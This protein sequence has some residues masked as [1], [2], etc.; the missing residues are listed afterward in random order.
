MLGRSLRLGALSVTGVAMLLASQVGVG[1]TA[2][3]EINSQGGYQA[4]PAKLSDGGHQA[5]YSWDASWKCRIP[6]SA[7]IAGVSTSGKGTVQASYG[8]WTT[9]TSDPCA[10]GSSFTTTITFTYTDKLGSISFSAPME[11]LGS[12]SSNGTTTQTWC[13]SQYNT[14]Y[15]YPN[16]I[17]ITGTGLYTPIN[18][19][20][21]FELGVRT[22]ARG[23]QVFF[24]ADD[25]YGQSDQ[26]Y[27]Y[28]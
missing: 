22:D 2:T 21:G 1:A 14:S 17:T 11:V 9:S 25:Q 5:P 24:A 3:N 23:G 16:N 4:C 19:L 18:E 12:S 7:T 10:N 15:P 26:C 28:A 13:L 27:P 6:I 20:C 8:I